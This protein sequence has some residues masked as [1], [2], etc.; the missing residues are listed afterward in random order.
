LV[1]KDT[2][3]RDIFDD[4]KVSCILEAVRHADSSIKGFYVDENCP[5]YDEWSFAS[6]EKN[7][8][9]EYAVLKSWDSALEDFIL[10]EEFNELGAGYA[11]EG[12][13]YFDR[14][15][16]VWEYWFYKDRNGYDNFGYWYSF[17]LEKFEYIDQTMAYCVGTFDNS[18]N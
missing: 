2:D 12:R 15:S 9:G 7:K 17:D 5:Y 3:R 8:D 18:T 11:Q 10:V 16:L 14:S 1:D 4:S 6:L 13:N